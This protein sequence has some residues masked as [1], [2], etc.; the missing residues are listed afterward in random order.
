MIK[1]K[2]NGTGMWAWFLQRITGIIIVLFL[3]LHLWSIHFT[4]SFLIWMMVSPYF[5]P[6]LLALLLIH[7][8]NGIRVFII[9][10][11]IKLR[12]QRILFWILMILSAA[13]LFYAVYVRLMR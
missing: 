3:F 6:I 2:Q 7:G 8:L 11:G 1:E 5:F 4:K 10:F 9:D 13:I 12:T